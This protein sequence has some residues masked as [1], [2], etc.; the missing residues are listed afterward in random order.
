[1]VII[2]IYGLTYVMHERPP[3]HGRRKLKRFRWRINNV[4]SSDGVGVQV[5]QKKKYIA[6]SGVIWVWGQLSSL[7]FR[8]IESLCSLKFF[9]F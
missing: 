1:M 4:L 2:P 5:E 9:T 6:V 8:L 3:Q 7:A